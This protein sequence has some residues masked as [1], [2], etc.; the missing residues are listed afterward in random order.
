MSSSPEPE[1]I[2]FH[3]NRDSKDVI[4]LRILR[5]RGYFGLSGSAQCNDKSTF[6]KEAGV[7]ELVVG[8]VM[9]QPEAEV[10]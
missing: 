2:A 6:G 7:S 9:M 5:W 1:F 4:P 3:S 8:Q 10:T